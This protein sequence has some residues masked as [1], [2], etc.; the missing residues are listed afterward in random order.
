LRK[1]RM[2]AGRDLPVRSV[3]P[4]DKSTSVAVSSALHSQVISKLKMREVGLVLDFIYSFE[5]HSISTYLKSLKQ[6]QQRGTTSTAKNVDY[7]NSNNF[8]KEHTSID[9]NRYERSGHMEGEQ[10]HV[11][12]ESLENIREQVMRE[13]QMEV[14]ES[15]EGLISTNGK[16][17]IQN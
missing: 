7:I 2:E 1:R 4:T 9:L 15:L 5:S 14:A 12:M 13:T 16:I 11:N 3:Q 10:G 8:T 6:Q 17:Y